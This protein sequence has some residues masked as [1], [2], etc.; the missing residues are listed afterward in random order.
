MATASRKTVAM[1]FLGG[2]TI[3]ERN[4]LGDTV[5]KAAHVKPWLKA[6][7]EMDIIAETQGVFIASGI[8][9]VGVP[10]WQQ[11]AEAIRELYDEVD[12]FVIVHQLETIPAAATA[13]SLMFTS[14]GKPVVLCGSALVSLEER[15]PGRRSIKNVVA[16]FGAKASFI[17]A[18][19]VAVSDISGV[20]VVYGSHIYR[21]NTVVGP[22]TA[23]HGDILGKI[24]FGI[25]FFGHHD[26]RHGRALKIVSSFAT[27][28]D[29]VEYL[30]GVDV[31]HLVHIP[32]GT[33]A[34][35]LT[36]PEATQALSNAVIQVRAVVPETMPV[37]LYGSDSSGTMSGV[38]P[39]RALS[40]SAALLKTMWALGQT[41]DLKK[42]RKLLS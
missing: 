5:T 38:C 41:S 21:G 29:V 36:A 11:V 15:S 3:D 4:R 28:I 40:R 33:V 26:A 37:I 6:M 18:V 39:V 12:G 24:D 42:L 25:R 9:A 13:L 7:S 17:N 27:N 20:V 34:V 30:P 31:R 19:Q 1:L 35:F 14:L 23:V 32:R 16:D 22:M 2:A 8:A 10:E